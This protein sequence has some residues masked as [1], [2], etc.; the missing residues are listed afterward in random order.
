MKNKKLISSDAKYLLLE[1]YR[2]AVDVA[3]RM[4]AR[5]ELINK[6]FISAHAIIFT[7]LASQE[8]HSSVSMLLP[9]F[10]IFLSF[11]W[12][13]II[14][15]YRVLNNAKFEVIEEMETRLPWNV[16]KSE[17]DKL[18]RGRNKKTYHN[19]SSVELKI[20]FLFSFLYFIFFFLSIWNF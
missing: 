4:N 9:V 13:S 5:K 16:F 15:N 11:I 7:Y 1:Q 14:R 18:G 12:A 3:D 19:I 6:L 8:I 17:W 2:I 20:P 10:G